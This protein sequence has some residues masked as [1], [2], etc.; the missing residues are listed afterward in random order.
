MPSRRAESGIGGNAR[1]RPEGE[2]LRTPPSPRPYSPCAERPRG[3]ASARPA[4]P[5]SSRTKSVVVLRP[6]A[7]D[8]ATGLNELPAFPAAPIEKAR[9]CRAEVAMQ[10]EQ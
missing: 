8:D 1:H 4:A 9:R 2:F 10:K 7:S 3:R 6:A 5:I